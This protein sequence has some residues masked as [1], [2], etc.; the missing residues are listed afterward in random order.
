MSLS[1][2]TLTTIEVIIGLIIWCLLALVAICVVAQ[3]SIQ[4]PVRGPKEERP[5]DQV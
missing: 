4:S 5:N 1:L 2:T 3:G